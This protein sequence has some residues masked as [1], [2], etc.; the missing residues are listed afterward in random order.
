MKVFCTFCKKE[1]N[2]SPAHISKNNFCCKLCYTEAKKIY[3]ELHPSYNGGQYVQC[4]QCGKDTYKNPLTLK[5][6]KHN[7][8]SKECLTIWK[9]SS[10]NR[11]L[12]PNYKNA[13]LTKV[14]LV[15]GISFTTY[16]ER[17]ATCSLVCGNKAKEKKQLL[18]CIN[19]NK[20]YT[21][22]PS[23]IY[24]ANKRR[25]VNN[26]CSKDCMYTYY[27]GEN[28]Y[29]WVKDR[30]Q[31]K[32]PHNTIRWSKQM[33]DWRKD[34]Y[35]RDN[36]TCQMCDNRSTKNNVVLLNAHHI[37][38]FSDNER[39]RFDTNNGIT[40]CEDCHKLTYGK[41]QDFEEHFKDKIKEKENL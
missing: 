14:C 35:T 39:L 5:N 6:N 18:V 9:S 25:Q 8:C 31:L 16:F 34:I 29:S 26:F 32:D 22:I 30:T 27:Q 3:K 19:C 15:C 33:I 17:Q 4:A 7:F 21:V 12:T 20:E 24:W 2:R 40:L 23:T 38:R 36:Y 41:E 28:H 1:I 37:V 13:L 10:D 11:V